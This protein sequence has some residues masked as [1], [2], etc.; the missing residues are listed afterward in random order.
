MFTKER[1]LLFLLVFT[2]VIAELDTRLDMHFPY[3]F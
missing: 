1:E 2:S 3:T